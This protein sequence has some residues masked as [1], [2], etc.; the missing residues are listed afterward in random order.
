MMNTMIDKQDI[1]IHKQVCSLIIQLGRVVATLHPSQWL[2]YQP[3]NRGGQVSHRM[4]I[5]RHDSCLFH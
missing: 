5:S 3:T 1:H 4:L 2:R